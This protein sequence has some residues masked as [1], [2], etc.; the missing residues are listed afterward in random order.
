M[1]WY[2]FCAV[3]VACALFVPAPVR[4]ASYTMSEAVRQALESNPGVESSR[5]SVDA[6]E[7][8]RKAARSSFGPAVSSTYSYTR[9]NEDRPSRHE[10][11]SYM[12]SVEASQPL[13]T[14]FQL[15][16]GYQKAAL[17][18]D[19]QVLQ[20]D[21][22]RLAVVARVQARFLL[23][24]KAEE[25]IRSTRRSLERA[26]AQLALARAAYNVGTRPRLDVLQ[27]ELDVSRTEAT[28]IQNE[29]ERDI[30]RAELNTLLNLPVDSATEYVGDLKPLPFELTLE[31]CLELAF[32]QR[33]DLLMARKS[34]EIAEKDLG[35]VRG[36]WYPRL[37]AFFNWNTSG[38]RAGAAGSRYSPDGYSEWQTGV[39]ATWDLFTSG[40][41]WFSAGQARSQIAALEAQA[42]SAFN[43]SAFEVKSYL[44]NVQDAK[45]MIAVAER[46]VVS[47]RE[48]Y[49]DARMRYELQLGTNLDLLTAQSDLASAEL[50]LISAKT[51]YLT[52]LSRLYAAIGEIHPGLDVQGEPAV[53]SVSVD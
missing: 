31:R 1:V 2:R 12:W 45:R 44:L 24:L 43:E 20:L 7:A 52:A 48:S 9:Y 46:S 30:D 13:F 33:P 10:R 19:S 4:A 36:S 29:N 14:G 26:R 15:L 49:D 32:R 38:A 34:V 50:S 28:L 23:Y 39:I 18:K 42:R 27:A 40:Q 17:H 3:A 21:N 22:T 51:D 53:R 6:A 37:S 8:G 16:N 41:R 5:H 47:A 11:N 25:N 35:I